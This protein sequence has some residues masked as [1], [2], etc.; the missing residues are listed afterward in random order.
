M[1]FKDILNNCENVDII[2]ALLNNDI[3]HMH[4]E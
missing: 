1:L 3:M 4:R 2:S